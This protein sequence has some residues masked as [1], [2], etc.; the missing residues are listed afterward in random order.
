[1]SADTPAS[2]PWLPVGASGR[3]LPDWARDASLGIFVHWGAYSVPAWAEPSGALGA[4]PDDEWYTHNA[5]AEWYANT[6]RIEGSPAADHHARV[7]GGAPYE[8]FLDEWRAEAYDPVGWARLFRAVGADYVVPTTKHHD[9]IALWDAPGTDLTTVARGPRRDLIAPLADAV[10][11]EGLRFGVY[12]SGGLDWSVTD[13]PPHRSTPDLEAL[14]PQDAAYH[15]YA[16]AHVADLVE[17]FR[18][19]VLWN[20]ID[21]PDAGKAP[22]PGSLDALIAEYRERVPEGI[23]NDR[24]GADVWDFRTSEYDA[25]GDHE[26]D[27]G[28]EHCRGLGYSFGFNAVEDA[29]LTLSPREL[30]R[31][32]A[33]VVSRGG[34][35][36]LNVGPT[37]AGEIPRVQRA[38][39]EG[40][41]AW[42]TAIKPSTIGRGPVA[43]ED[44]EVTDAT[45]WR[46]WA[47]ADGIVAVTDSDEASARSFDGRPVT[48]IALP[49]E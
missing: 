16:R 48:V 49:E 9:G 15:A 17:R 41:A 28:W 31:L 2:T 18:P 6:I 14:R 47:N 26:S 23:V 13:A 3:P 35:L 8:A 12:Y 22:G 4:V 33:D 38:T 42:L 1:M 36:L 46:G 37:A 34:R 5:Y 21:W 29:S 10:R 32:Y 19:D 24:W 45:W 27:P 43:A 30:A 20:D 40:A 25:H 7:H 39:L 11:A 44:L